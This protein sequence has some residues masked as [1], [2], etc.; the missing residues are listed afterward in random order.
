[1]TT[2]FAAFVTQRVPPA[3]SESG[4]FE[5]TASYQRRLLQIGGV[6]ARDR[7]ET[8]SLSWCGMVATLRPV[9]TKWPNQAEFRGFVLNAPLSSAICR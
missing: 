6:N 2:E 1:V 8:F 7:P 5:N 3:R 4:S 9:I